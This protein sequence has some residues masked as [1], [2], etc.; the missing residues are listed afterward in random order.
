MSRAAGSAELLAGLSG[1][2]RVVGSGWWVQGGEEG[3]RAGW[4]VGRRWAAGPDAYVCSAAY[5]LKDAPQAQGCPT[6]LSP[7]NGRSLWSWKLPQG[8][9]EADSEEAEPL[10]L[11]SVS[12]GANSTMPVGVWRGGG[13]G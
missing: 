8:T 5:R 9:T 2:R 7:V 12:R 13:R 6:H 11:R 3:K 10:R 1:G 4:Q